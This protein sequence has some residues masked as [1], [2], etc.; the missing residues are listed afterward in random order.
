MITVVGV[1][2]ISLEPPNWQAAVRKVVE[3]TL[4]LVVVD[5]QGRDGT[6][7]RRFGD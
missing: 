6:Q 1:D 5:G 4:A 7:P 2:Q 3:G